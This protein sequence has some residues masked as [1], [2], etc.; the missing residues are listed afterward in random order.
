MTD[1]EQLLFSIGYCTFMLLLF[2]LFQKYPPKKINLFYGYRT[3]RSMIN[4]TTWKEANQYSLRLS[5]LF[6]VYSFAFPIILY[7]TYPGYN[8]LI[9]I[10]VNTLLILSVYFFTEKHLNQLFDKNG[11]LK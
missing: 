11:N 8:F 10:I 1:N 2:F 5:V 9:T 6:C 7:F 3:Q 4:E